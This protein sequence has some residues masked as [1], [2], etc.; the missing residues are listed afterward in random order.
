MLLVYTHKITPRLTYI[1]RHVFVRVLHIP[2]DFTTKV[3][4]FIAH[5]GPKITY[6]K[7]PLGKEFFIRNHDLLFDQGIND[8][9]I[10]LS[11]WDDIPCFFPTGEKSS[12]PFDLFAASFYLITRYEEYQP[13][14]TD[15]HG[16]FSANQSLAFQGDFLEK[17]L[18]DVWAF[19]LLK[20]LQKKFPDYEFPTRDFRFISTININEAF[21][22]KHKGLIR[23]I[24][25]FFSDLVK[26][27]FRGIIRQIAVVLSIKE[28]P[29]NTYEHLLELRKQYKVRTLFFFLFSEYTTFDKN[30]S[31][32]NN[33]YKLLVK[34]VIDYAPF[35]Q[36]FSYY[37]MSNA[38]KLN[39][40][41]NR[42]ENIVN[43]PINKSRQHYNRF[44][45]P[46]TYQNLIDIGV[47]EDYS[48]GYYTHSGF[49]A[50]TC[51]PFYFYDLDYEIK[52]PLLI[53]P[54]VVNDDTLQKQQLTKKEALLKIETLI[55]EVQ[56]VNG[57]FISVFH[58]SSLSDMP[59]KKN[60]ET[61]YE[62]VLSKLNK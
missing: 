58:N 46:K 7:I 41:I 56:E 51:T 47:T 20:S 55:H 16:R 24:G 53:Y 3:E 54:F 39:K 44:E 42:F 1:F 27:N 60:W 48:M 9:T 8:R 50:S 14:V 62:N 6:S 33:R 12:I 21:A 18:V 35:G 34:S 38:K 11:Y 10:K 28:D 45:V 49:R 13:H 43:M 25:S 52:T 29:Y 4:E 5:N 26:F 2:I 59:K 19:K 15:K 22:F 30:V 31:T 32:T 57:T 23:N 36:L 40:E 17:P 61:L 37:T